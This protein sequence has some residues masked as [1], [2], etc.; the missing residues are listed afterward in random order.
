MQIYI[1]LE[2]LHQTIQNRKMN[3]FYTLKSPKSL[4]LVKL[5]F[6]QREGV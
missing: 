3:Q 2:H 5:S 4:T 6:L 1:L